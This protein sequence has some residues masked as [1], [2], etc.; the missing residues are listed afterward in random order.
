VKGSGVEV[1][2][3]A[4]SSPGA[5]RDFAFREERL[6]RR[7]G[8]GGGGGAQKGH[9]PCSSSCANAQRHGGSWTGLGGSIGQGRLGSAR[10]AATCGHEKAL[11]GFESIV[12]N[13]FEHR[14]PLRLPQ[15][16]LPF[17]AACIPSIGWAIVWAASLLGNLPVT[18]FYLRNPSAERCALVTLGW[19]GIGPLG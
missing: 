19:C 4:V 15:S 18:A 6:H 8:G 17:P 11:K 13:R 10:L 3:R 9:P 14:F 2:S 12:A 1:R 16:S 5:I 7:G